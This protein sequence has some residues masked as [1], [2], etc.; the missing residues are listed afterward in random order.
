MAAQAPGEGPSRPN[1]IADNRDPSR[2]ERDIQQQL[3]GQSLDFPS[4]LA[5]STIYRA[6]GA[7]RR[8]A[9][10][11]LLSEAGLSWGGF[12]ILWHLWVWGDTDTASLAADCDLA[13]G[14]LTGMVATLERQNLVSRHRLD[15]DRRR[16]TVTLTETGRTLVSELFPRFNEFEASMTATLTDGE[17]ESLARLLDVVVTNTG[18]NTGNNAF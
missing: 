15:R 17:K 18:D 13:R 5:V 2:V 8:R 1:T 9:E 12:T 10:R 7:L 14:T 6:A 16:V 11:D 4:M 3:A